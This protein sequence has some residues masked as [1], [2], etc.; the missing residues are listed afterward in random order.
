MKVYLAGFK[1]IAK[2]YKKDTSK[3]N[4]LSSFFEHK[5]GNF[6]DYV[7]ND[8]HILDSGAFSFF[9]GKKVDWKDYT[10]KYCEFIKKTNQSLFFELDIDSLTSL[11]YAENIRTEIE[12]KT[13]KQPIVVWHPSRGI[14]YWHKM[15]ENYNYVAISASGAYQSRWTRTEKGVLVM[16]K[17]ITIA[18]K[19]KTKV[20][21][22]GYTNIEKLKE[23]KFDSVDSTS[24]LM[25]SR[26]GEFHWFEKGVIK[27]T[28]PRELKRETIKSKQTE[29][30]INNLNQWVKFQK[31]ADKNL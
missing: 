2:H 16:K 14:D 7:Y 10:K 18:K 27:K 5:T 31:Y 12:Q 17:M 29:M 24:W 9:G 11:E 30:L 22:L 1:T 8:N 13:G 20:H 6:G 23:L 19:N 15:C 4:I 26:F 21:G 25:A 28:T 3:I